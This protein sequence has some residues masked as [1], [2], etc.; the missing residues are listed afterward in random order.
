M[1]VIVSGS[2][3]ILVGGLEG[4]VVVIVGSG[5]GA[6]IVVQLEGTIVVSGISS[7]A[8]V[9]VV[10]VGTGAGSTGVEWSSGTLVEGLEGT[11]VVVV[12]VNRGGVAGRL[13]GTETRTGHAT[14]DLICILDPLELPPVFL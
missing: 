9:A 1:V 6:T 5:A 12:A 7:G 2:G 13:N 14:T 10:V 8:T 11:I 3:K 4:T